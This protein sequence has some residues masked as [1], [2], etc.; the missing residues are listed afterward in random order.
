M[1]VIFNVNAIF[2]KDGQF[3]KAKEANIEIKK[4]TII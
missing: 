4:R 2:Y 1:I 3:I